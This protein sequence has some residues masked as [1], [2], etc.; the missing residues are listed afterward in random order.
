MQELYWVW[1]NL[2]RGAEAVFK[3][4]DRE[5]HNLESCVPDEDPPVTRQRPLQRPS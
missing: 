1:W 2:D 4:A 3:G 5:A